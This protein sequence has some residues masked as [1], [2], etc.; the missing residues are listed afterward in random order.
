MAQ[1]VRRFGRQLEKMPVTGQR[2]TALGETDRVIEISPGAVDSTQGSQCGDQAVR[3]IE[4]LR[5]PYRFLRLEPPLVEL[6][7]LSKGESPEDTRHHGRIPRKATAFAN[8]IALEQLD[9][10]R[11]ELVGPSIVAGDEVGRAEVI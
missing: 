7:P 5:E 4:R 10:P 2:E 8:P 3:V 9:D 6:A 11:E 1:L